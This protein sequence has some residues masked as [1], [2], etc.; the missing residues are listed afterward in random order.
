MATTLFCRRE[1]LIGFGSLGAAVAAAACRAT[2]RNGARSD[3]Y[4][5]EGCEAALERPAPSL[6]WDV[7][8]RQG[9]PG[10]PLWLEGRVTMPDGRTPAADVVV[11]LHQTNA[12]G[13]YANGSSETVWSRRHGRLRAWARTDSKGRYRFRTIKPAPYPDRTIPAHIHLTI[14]E[15]GRRPYY[16]DDV[17]FE[18]EFKVDASYRAGQELRGGSGIVRLTR[19]EAGRLRA[20]RDII[21][22]RHP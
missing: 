4:H 11:Y 13:L 12:Q 14:L 10:A 2:P 7:D 8:V 19:D 3:L 21:L 6:S 20:T 5:C 17:V 1:T 22:E 18:G 15:P 16:V 9:E